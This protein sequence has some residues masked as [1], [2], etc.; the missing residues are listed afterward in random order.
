MKTFNKDMLK[1]IENLGN[2]DKIRYLLDLKFSTTQVVYIL[3]KLEV[4]T[5]N[6]NY[7][8][9]Q[10]VNNILNKPRPT[11]KKKIEEVKFEI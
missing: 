1:E 11:N 9:Y 7:I 8:S 10:Y 2:V 5:K 3:K 6:D 4:K